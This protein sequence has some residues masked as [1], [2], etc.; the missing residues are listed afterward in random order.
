MSHPHYDSSRLLMSHVVFSTHYESRY[1]RLAYDDSFPFVYKT[2][3]SLETA[4]GSFS[5]RAIQEISAYEP[6]PFKVP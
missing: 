1:L 5:F 3:V 2:T 6:G 4:L